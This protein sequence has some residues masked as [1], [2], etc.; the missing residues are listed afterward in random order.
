VR[1]SLVRYRSVFRAVQTPTRIPDHHR[2]EKHVTS[3]GSWKRVPYV[4][5]CFA[6]QASLW[7]GCIN[8]GVAIRTHQVIQVTCR[9]VSRSLARGLQRAGRLVPPWRI[10]EGPTN[11]FKTRSMR[12]VHFSPCKHST[13]DEMRIRPA[14]LQTRF[15]DGER[16]FMYRLR[17]GATVQ[18][19]RALYIARIV[20]NLTLRNVT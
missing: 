11:S 3:L 12:S 4:R 7:Y 19:R 1:A 9:L 13:V 6:L 10:M 2:N 15:S 16:N 8:V 14:K 5:R 17:D 18:R 20:R